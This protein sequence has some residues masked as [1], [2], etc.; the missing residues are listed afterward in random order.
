MRK[1]E[2]LQ[3]A[4]GSVKR[5]MKTLFDTPIVSRPLKNA[6]CFALPFGPHLSTM[7]SQVAG[8]IEAFLP[9]R[10]NNRVPLFL[11]QLPES[12]CRSFSLT[13]TLKDVK[14]YKE[15]VR[16]AAVAFRMCPFGQKQRFVGRTIETWEIIT[17]QYYWKWEFELPLSNKRSNFI[18]SSVS[19]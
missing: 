4:G 8:E 6:R 19:N 11:K 13:Y 12:L 2:K 5:N 7:M 10:Q 18:G 9:M 14:Q 16:V 1:K 15:I 3:I 17:V